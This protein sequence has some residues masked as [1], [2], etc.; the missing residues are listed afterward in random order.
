M[1]KKL[2]I[3]WAL[4]SALLFSGCAKNNSNCSDGALTAEEMAWMDPYSV[5]GNGY[6]TEFM[7]TYSSSNGSD[8]SFIKRCIDYGLGYN[9]KEENCPN[10]YYATGYEAVVFV[11]NIC[12]YQIVTQ[13]NSKPYINFSANSGATAN[14]Y[15]TITDYPL[16]NNLY[17]ITKD[18]NTVASNVPFEILYSKTEGI[19]MMR[20]TGG[21]VLTKN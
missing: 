9:S 7:Y 18:S 17:H 13:H 14:I 12:A 16:S 15:Y 19:K 3:C 21:K 5:Y 8:S 4:L 10:H 20:F 6:N 1:S 11:K 2:F